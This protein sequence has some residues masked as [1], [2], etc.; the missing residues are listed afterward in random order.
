[1]DA[2]PQACTNPQ[3]TLAVIGPTVSNS[4]GACGAS[5]MCAGVA[6]KVKKAALHIFQTQSKVARDKGTLPDTAAAKL[7]ASTQHQDPRVATV[8]IE[9][10]PLVVAKGDRDAI[11][12]LVKSLKNE[13]VSHLR[14]TRPLADLPSVPCFALDS[15]CSVVM[16][17][18][19]ASS[20]WR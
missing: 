16:R 4:D 6:A 8:A 9:A 7:I 3:L 18:R 2:Q 20:R 13:C 19:L 12:A 1:M 11:M 17:F 10:L 14:A 5:D 15:D